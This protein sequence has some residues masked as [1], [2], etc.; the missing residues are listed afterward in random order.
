VARS[1]LIRGARQLLTLHGPPGPRRGAGLQE[2]GII[3][4]GAVLIRDGLIHDVG[5]SRRVEALIEARNAA[6]INAAGRVVLPGFVDS[7]THL[8]A[9]PLRAMDSGRPSQTEAYSK[10]IQLTSQRSLETQG[11]RLLEDFVRHGTTTVEAKSGLGANERGELKILRANAVLNRRTQMVASTFTATR[12]VSSESSSG[13]YLEGVCTRILPVIRRRRLAEFADI[14]AESGIFSIEQVRRYLSGAK[15]LGFAPKVQTGQTGSSGAVAE[16]VRFG[17]VSVDHLLYVSDDDLQALA[18]SNTIATL[19]PG[20]VFFKGT[21]RFAPARTLIERGAAVA[22]ATNYNPLTSPSRSMQMMIAL[23]CLKM[24]MTAAEAISAA[25]INGACAVRRSDRIGSLEY[26]KQADVILLAISDY[27]EIP[28][29]FGVNLV[30]AV[31]RSGQVV[32]RRSE[33]K[34]PSPQ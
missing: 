21:G 5:P 20:S 16:A 8:V 2:L 9:G 1:I 14:Y 12:R 25:T 33:V 17:A 10:I 27:R 31:L 4:D 32:Y 26:G 29:H 11:L 30:D 24:G 3:A 19:L 34:W 13:E 22:L 6:E 7:H 18:E 23:A 28:Y 15:S